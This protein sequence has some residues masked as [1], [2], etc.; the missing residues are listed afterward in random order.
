MSYEPHRARKRF[1]QNFLHDK[2]V[3]GRIVTAIDPQANETLLEIGPGL[4]ALTGP[5][6]QAAGKMHAVEIDR[7]LIARLPDAMAPFGELTLYEQD[8]LKLELATLMPEHK[9]IRVVG[10]LPYNISTPLLFHL[11][12]QVD[13]I[14][15]MHF[16]LQKEVVERM[17][18]AP[19]SKTYGRLSVMLQ[20]HCKVVPLFIVKPG[21]FSPPPKVESAIIR[22][23]PYQTPPYDVGDY[24]LFR[25]VVTQAFSQRRKTLRNAVNGIASLEHIEAAGLDPSCRPET[26]GG[27][28]FAKLCLQVINNP[29]A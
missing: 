18:A 1:G 26:L 2:T 17:S 20:Y 4:G 11:F 12:D 14:Q 9:N 22:L 28:A 15:D 10:N 8:A 7:D 25:K 24:G 16:M 23:K 6:L 13:R 29:L 19:G 27:D 21:A 3:I 5:L